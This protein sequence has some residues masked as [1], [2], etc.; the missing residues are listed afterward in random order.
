MVRPIFRATATRSFIPT[1]SPA[2]AAKVLRGIGS[3]GLLVHPCRP[4]VGSNSCLD[5]NSVDRDTNGDYL[6]SARHTSTIYRISGKQATSAPAGQIL[7][8]LGG[9]HSTFTTNYNFSSQHMA[10]FL[11]SSGSTTTISLFDDATDGTYFSSTYSSG[12][13]VNVDTQ[14]RASSL[15]HRY[16]SPVGAISTSQGSM[17]VLSNSNALLGWGSQPYYSE[18][19]QDGTLLYHAQ[20]GSLPGG[21]VLAGINNYRAY[22]T[23]WLAAPAAPPDLVIYTQR[24]SNSTVFGYASWNGATSVAR[25]RFRGGP[26]NDTSTFSTLSTVG[27]I[28]FETGAVMQRGGTGKSGILYVVVDALNTDGRVLRTS[29]VVKTFVPGSGVSGCGTASCAAGTDYTTATNIAGLC[30]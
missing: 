13:I 20:F 5:I 1:S 14:S 4:P 16:V 18:F 27:K 12:I 6:V 10:R 3:V 11:S 28:G 29:N 8:N 7:W 2:P 17:Q 19:A 24:C 22:K 26:R 9:K 23:E 30:S 15:N 25:W 21:G